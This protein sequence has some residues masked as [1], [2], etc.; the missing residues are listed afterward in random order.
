M[1][2][3]IIPLFST[4]LYKGKVEINNSIDENFLKSFTYTNPN[5]IGW[6]SNNQKILLN[7][8]FKYLKLEVDKHIDIFLYEVLKIAQGKPIHIQS[9]INKHCPDNYSKIHYH[10]NSFISGGVYLECPPN[11]GKLQFHTPQTP[12][13]T[14]GTIMPTVSEDNIF[15]CDSFGFEVERG[16]I[17]IF[18]SQTLHSVEKNMSDMDRYMIAFNYFLEGSIGGQTGEISIKVS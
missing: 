2:S 10:S 11:S 5:N 9:W 3:D 13:W 15:N 12:S 16:D 17:F 18:P 8:N 4:P 1:T 14:N 7:D 6:C